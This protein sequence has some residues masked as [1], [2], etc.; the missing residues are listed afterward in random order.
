MQKEHFLQLCM[1]EVKLTVRFS[2][3]AASNF[4]Q[5]NIV[6]S[7]CNC[8]IGS[9]MTLGLVQSAAPSL[10]RWNYDVSKKPSK[11]PTSS[12]R[13]I[14]RETICIEVGLRKT[15]RTK[16]LRYKDA[17]ETFHDILQLLNVS[18]KKKSV[19]EEAWLPDKNMP[20]NNIDII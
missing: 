10:S 15:R 13:L 4:S 3:H 19:E 9:D 1:L 7:A 11:L 2:K 5:S 6:L 16:Y 20:C 18:I 12:S 14:P 17:F 8:L